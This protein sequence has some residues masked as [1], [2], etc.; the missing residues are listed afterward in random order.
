MPPL[1][2][3]A[4][5]DIRG[6]TPLEL[7][8]LHRK[9][10][11]A[12]AEA[13]KRTFGMASQMLSAAALPMADR[14]SR[15]WL[16]KSHNPYLGEIDEMAATLDIPG[17][18]TLNICLE[19]GCTGGVWRSEDGP[20]LRRT[21]DWPFP[22]LGEHIVVARQDGPG[23]EFF[24]VTWPSI[25]GIL[26][27]VAPGRFAA[28]INQGPLRRCGAGL[29]G[30]WVLGRLAVGR[31]LALPPTHL[32]RRAFETAVDY[33]AAKAL[34]CNIPVAV[35]TIFILAGPR[36]SEGC[37][38]E[39]TETDFEAREMTDGQVSAANHFESRLAQIG[40]GWRARP[41]DSYG[42]S[43]GARALDSARALANEKPGF[44]W[45]VPPIANVNCRLAMIAKAA[46]GQLM[47]MGTAGAQPVTEVFRLPA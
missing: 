18:Y 20:L 35:P 24:N 26:Q 45:F 23:G 22:E 43:A 46:K 10:A 32:L 31:N 36:G 40:R 41:I 12:M 14:V 38:I 44:A 4:Y 39:R 27:A 2:K 21:L 19:W 9:S 28:A 15:R 42:R 37:V 5:A 25:S 16:E 30:D 8:F 6:H 17:V 34:L 3:I 11:R 33:A 13:A 29:I 1:A 47:V 7:L